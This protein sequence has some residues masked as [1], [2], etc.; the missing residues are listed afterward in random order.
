MG[1]WSHMAAPGPPVVH[2][3]G[4]CAIQLPSA[5]WCS[6]A[7]SAGALRLTIGLLATMS[8]LVVG[9]LITAAKTAYDTQTAEFRRM[10]AEIILLDRALAHYRPEAGAAREH[11]GRT[12]S[13]ILGQ[14]DYPARCGRNRSGWEWTSR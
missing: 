8:V 10:S 5:W 2:S 6:S 1:P 4:P 12:V 14:M 11:L 7:C 3:P 13:G 9:L